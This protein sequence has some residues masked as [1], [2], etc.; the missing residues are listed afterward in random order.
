MMD[1]ANTRPQSQRDRGLE[2]ETR[3][4]RTDQPPDPSSEGTH[5]FPVWI[6]RK[7]LD[8]FNK[9]NSYVLAANSVGCCKESVRR[10]DNRLIPYRMGGGMAKH[11]LTGEDQLLLSICLFIYPNALANDLCLLIF[12]NEGRLSCGGAT[13]WVLP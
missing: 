10:W 9:T 12:E 5:G 11:N 13:N 2:R 3:V 1:P 8:V 4:A 6:R 7:A